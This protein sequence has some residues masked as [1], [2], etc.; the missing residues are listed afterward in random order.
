HR[1]SRAPCGSKTPASVTGRVVTR[2]HTGTEGS[3]RRL[4][5]TTAGISAR[6]RTIA[7]HRSG[8]SSRRRTVFPISPVVVSWP[9]K[10]SENRIEAIS[11]SVSRPGVLVVDRQQIAGQIIA[12]RRV[13]V[14][15]QLAQ[16]APVRRHVRGDLDLI[17]GA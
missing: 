14:V 13:L 3:N 9:A 16:V 17:L 6:S 1:N 5:S 12:P 8:A 4:S 2:R 11:A 10:L 7:S 15:D